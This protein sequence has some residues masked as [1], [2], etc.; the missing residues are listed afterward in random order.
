MS[1]QRGC[2]VGT[3]APC[4]P[5]A[6]LVTR[7][8]HSPNSWRAS[9]TVSPCTMLSLATGLLPVGRMRCH[10]LRQAGLLSPVPVM[11]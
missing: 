7:V 8:A 3:C 1:M 10:K 4:W 2:T 5:G 9:D 6:H 11:L